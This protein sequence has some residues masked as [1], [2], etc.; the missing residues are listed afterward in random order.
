MKETVILLLNAECE[1]ASRTRDGRVVRC[2]WAVLARAQY[3]DM[4]EMRFGT[5]RAGGIHLG[6][7]ST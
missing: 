2:E 1:L 3:V 6:R 5:R 7:G 4:D